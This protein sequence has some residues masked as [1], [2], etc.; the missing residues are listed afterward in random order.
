MDV[1]SERRFFTNNKAVIVTS[2]KPIGTSVSRATTYELDPGS[3]YGY[4]KPSR[5]RKVTFKMNATLRR[6]FGIFTLVYPDK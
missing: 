3:I 5:M 1:S 6:G 4:E 2:I